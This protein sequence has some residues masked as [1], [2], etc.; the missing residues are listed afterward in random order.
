[1]KP[2]TLSYQS[3]CVNVPSFLQTVITQIKCF[4]SLCIDAAIAIAVRLSVRLF[5]CVFHA[6]GPRQ[7]GSKYR[8]TV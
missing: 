7:N 4:L 2:D 8:N 6:S 3:S 1:M 5:V